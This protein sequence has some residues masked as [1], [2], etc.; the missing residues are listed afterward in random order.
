VEPAQKEVR[1]D[2]KSEE[3]AQKE[4]RSDPKNVEPAQKIVILKESK[5][6]KI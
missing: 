1:G 5:L 6:L 2:L 4:V 3:A